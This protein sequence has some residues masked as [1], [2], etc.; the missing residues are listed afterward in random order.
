V[1]ALFSRSRAFRLSAFPRL[2]GL[3]AFFGGGID[4]L[5]WEACDLICTKFPK[6]ICQN[7][8][9]GAQGYPGGP[10]GPAEVLWGTQ[11]GATWK[12][13]VSQDPAVV[14]PATQ[15]GPYKPLSLIF[16]TLRKSLRFLP[17]QD[18]AVDERH[19]GPDWCCGTVLGQAPSS[20]A[21][22]E[23]HSADHRPRQPCALL[24]YFQTTLPRKPSVSKFAA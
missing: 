20:W 24:D 17:G 10:N 16:S 21:K 4:F 15:L 14:G 9:R 1:A 12:C 2:A 19:Y 23:V 11:G 7:I 18:T 13:A 6:D 22:Y 5:L 8:S 3:S